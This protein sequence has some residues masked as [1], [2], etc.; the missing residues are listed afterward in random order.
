MHICKKFMLIII[1]RLS[2]ILRC[3][4]C[5]SIL[6][7]ILICIYTIYCTMSTVIRVVLR[8]VRSSRPLG[9]WHALARLAGIRKE[10]AFLYSK[11]LKVHTLAI[12]TCYSHHI[13]HNYIPYHL[14]YTHITIYLLSFAYIHICTLFSLYI[15]KHTYIN[16]PYSYIYTLHT[17]AHIIYTEIY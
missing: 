1:T 8:D 9:R 17:H 2:V 15:P 3:N 14:H 6:I 7:P 11:L 10:Y 5:W 16:T 12:Y 4:I 13:R